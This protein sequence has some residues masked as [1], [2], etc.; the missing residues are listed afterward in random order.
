[1]LDKKTLNMLDDTIEQL[2][3]NVY[4]MTGTKIAI[5]YFMF[6]DP[7]SSEKIAQEEGGVIC[8]AVVKKL[9]PEEIALG[10]MSCA[11]GLN[12]LAGGQSED[13]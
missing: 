8:G 5:T 6:L 4:K 3:E 7:V 13:I 9:S 11:Q 1:M 12:K 10:Y 2:A